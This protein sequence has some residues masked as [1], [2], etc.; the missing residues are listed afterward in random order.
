MSRLTTQQIVN[1]Q[2]KK[3]KYVM[4]LSNINDT[5]IYVTGTVSRTLL[6][7]LL[8]PTQ[9]ISILNGPCKYGLF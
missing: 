5:I 9:L 2:N 1:T 6:P 7:I 8:P 3:G 4:V